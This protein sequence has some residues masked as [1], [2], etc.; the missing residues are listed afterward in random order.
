MKIYGTAGAPEMR[1]AAI[2]S[3]A[4]QKNFGKL[5]IFLESFTNTFWSGKNSGITFWNIEG[6][7]LKK[8]TII[9]LEKFE[10]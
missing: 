3:L 10:R 7:S 2:L 4:L 6:A 9:F 1:F 5:P 8:W